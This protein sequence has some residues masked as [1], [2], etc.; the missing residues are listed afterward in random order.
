MYVL[1]AISQIKMSIC[2]LS[3]VWNGDCT[4]AAR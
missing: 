3:F 2:Q 4:F 1:Q